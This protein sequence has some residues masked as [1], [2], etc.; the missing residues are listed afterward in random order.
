MNKRRRDNCYFLVV[1]NAI[2]E[3]VLLTKLNE[4][5]KK[6]LLLQS[7]ILDAKIKFDLSHW[8]SSVF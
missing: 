8:Y 4:S 3:S 6:L 7:L 1:K 2:A 5:Q